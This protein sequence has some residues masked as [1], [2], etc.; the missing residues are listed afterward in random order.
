MT[1]NFFSSLNRCIEQWL[2]SATGKCPHC[3]AKAKRA[4][5]RVIYAKALKALDTSE[6]DHALRELEREKEARR[7]M[8]MEKA[9]MALKYQMALEDLSRM[10]AKF[11]AQ[12]SSRYEVQI[13]MTDKLLPHFIQP[14]LYDL[15]LLGPHPPHRFWRACK[16]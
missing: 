10:R 16:A 7:R 3:N 13:I 5:I 1:S 8:E 9:Q 4:D 2:K 15:I 11:E 6:R 14:L 12:G